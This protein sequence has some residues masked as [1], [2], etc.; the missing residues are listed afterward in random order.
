MTDTKAC[1]TC[2]F[3]D[4]RHADNSREPYVGRCCI[5]APKHGGWIGQLEVGASFPLTASTDWCG[6]HAAREDGDG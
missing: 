6:E 1:A 5:R 4:D 2:R 3:W